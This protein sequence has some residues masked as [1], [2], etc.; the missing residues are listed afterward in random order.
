M[1]KFKES[2]TAKNLLV[3]FAFESQANNRYLFFADQAKKDGYIQISKFFT[4]T[5]GQE[6]EHALRFF[7]FF[8]G[9][10]LEVTA[11]FLTG[12]IKGTYDNLIASADLENHVHTQLYPGFA[13]VA[14]DE[15]YE[16]AA[17][18]WDAIIVAE[19]HHEKLFSALA[20][21]VR[22]E[23]IFS[24]DEQTV[25]RCGNC[26]YLHEGPDAPK[27]CPACLRPYGYFEILCENV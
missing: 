15:N 7:K 27:Q 22:S 21:R 20:K 24:Q 12:V 14:R 18:T 26:G 1:T 8:N 13:A 17:E 25:W 16:R 5:A 11:T 19:R 9:G 23:K 10:E 2:R 4:E 3:S 6:F